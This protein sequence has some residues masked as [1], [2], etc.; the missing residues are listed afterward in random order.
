MS[1]PRYKDIPYGPHERNVL[2]LYPV[3]S[4]A[5]APVYVFIHGG[6]FRGGDKTRIPPALLEGCLR[7]GIAV[8]AINYRLSDTDP[9]PAAMEDSARAIQ[10]LRHKAGEWRLDGTR[11]AAG[12]GSAGGGITFWIGF[13]PDLADPA[14]DDPVARASTRLACIASWRGLLRRS[15]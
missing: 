4:D 14:S 6:G 1:E 5:P 15:W 2:D 8:A 3:A 12:G 9:Y 10:F 11:F 7:A 13:R